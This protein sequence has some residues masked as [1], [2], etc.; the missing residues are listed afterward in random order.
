MVITVLITTTIS[1]VTPIF[2]AHREL[3]LNACADC[4]VLGMLHNKVQL[5][6]VKYN[7]LNIT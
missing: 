5:H 1:G 4:L 7:A 6:L 3:Y 2:R